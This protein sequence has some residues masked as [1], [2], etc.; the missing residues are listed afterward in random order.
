MDSDDAFTSREFTAESVGWL[1]LALVLVA[2]MVGA[3][4]SGPLSS[5]QAASTSGRMTL[6]YQRITHQ[7]ADDHV[8]IEI[9]SGTGTETVT[10]QLGGDWLEGLDLRQI[11]PQAAEERGTPEGVDL[12]IPVRGTG[13]VRVVLSFRLRSL[14]PARGVLRAR[15]EEIRFTQFVLP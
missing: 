6:D 11:T 3:L 2:A 10:I 4:G 15:G 13:P 8:V 14:G 5:A 7:D 1:L 12:T 9:V